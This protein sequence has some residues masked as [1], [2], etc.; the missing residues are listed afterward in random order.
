[1]NP[2]PPVQSV[3]ARPRNLAEARLLVS[4][5]LTSRVARTSDVADGTTSAFSVASLAQVGRGNHAA[6]PVSLFDWLFRR[7]VVA[8][9]VASLLGGAGVLLFVYAHQPRSG[10]SSKRRRACS[11]SGRFGAW[12]TPVDAFA[13][14]SRRRYR[15]RDARRGCSSVERREKRGRPC[16]R[17]TAWSSQ[18][19]NAKASRPFVEATPRTRGDGH[20]GEAHFGTSA[21]RQARREVAVDPGGRV[22]ARGG[23]A[24]PRGEARRALAEAGD[25]DRPVEGAARG[26]RPAAAGAGKASEKT[27]RS[28]ERAYE[29]GRGA[30]PRRRPSRRR[31]RAAGAALKREGREAGSRAALARQTRAA[32][33]KRSPTERSRAARKGA[34]TKGPAKRAA[35]ARKA[36]ERAPR[37]RAASPRF[38]A[39]RRASDSTA[40]VTRRAG[41][42]APPRSLRERRGREP[43]CVWPRRARATGQASRLLA[44]RRPR[45][46][47]LRPRSEARATLGVRPGFQIRCEVAPAAS[48]GFDSRGFRKS[49]A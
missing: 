34:R 31:A 6:C 27:R 11:R 26:R 3:L 36:A 37:R 33:K 16:A 46:H 2:A 30:P 35:A 13:R 18:R 25:R 15:H 43:R 10:A 49:G 32:A 39:A 12:F 44:P 48:G 47:R 8:V 23:G 17:G 41:G 21:A 24:R 1:M 38:V 9:L 40:V 29:S 28:A 7:T 4:V 22:R 20:A 42:C 14:G 19:R 45:A 5:S